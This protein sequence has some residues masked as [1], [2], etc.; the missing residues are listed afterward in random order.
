MFTHVPKVSD[1]MD[2]LVQALSI[3]TA[4]GT[5]AP[6]VAQADGKGSGVAGGGG[7]GFFSGSAAVTIPPLRKGATFAERWNH[8]VLTAVH[9]RTVCALHTSPLP[10]VRWTH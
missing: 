9:D 5:A 7:G 6:A 1:L 4:D 10:A 3:P 2:A 8:S